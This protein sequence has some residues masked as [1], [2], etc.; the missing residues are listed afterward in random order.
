MQLTS[1]VHAAVPKDYERD[2]SDDLVTK[3][4]GNLLEEEH[5]LEN[6]W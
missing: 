3:N 2:F 5:L 4:G 6:I 1:S